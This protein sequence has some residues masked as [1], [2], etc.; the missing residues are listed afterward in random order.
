MSAGSELQTDKEHT[1][2]EE[3]SFLMVLA[4]PNASRMGL[5]CNSCFSSSPC[6]PKQGCTSVGFSALQ[7][8][9]FNLKQIFDFD[10][11]DKL[12]L[13]FSH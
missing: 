9:A 10:I 8:Q 13:L 7:H 11:F 1:N 4:F 6:R 2:R 3:L 5:A 12:L